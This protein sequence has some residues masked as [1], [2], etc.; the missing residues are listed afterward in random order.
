MN[1]SD[2]TSTNEV[3]QVKN[4][5][6]SYGNVRAVVDVSFSVQKG[7]IF[8]FLGPNGAGKT[9]TLNVLEGLR[10]ADHGRVTVLGMDV[11]TS[12]AQIKQFIGVQ[13]QSTSLLPDLTVIEQVKLFAELYGCQM[14]HAD[15]IALLERV[16]LAKK[17]DALPGK[18]S[19]SQRQRLAL[20]LA[21]VNEREVSC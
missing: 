21:L 5:S 12:A 13:L 20:A 6:K 11:N 18:L 7:E 3:I 16:G 4:L 9:T 15:G 17:A 2:S 8:G 10:K 14:T 1:F 19:G